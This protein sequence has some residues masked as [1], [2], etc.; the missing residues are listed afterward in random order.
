MKT[1]KTT[2]LLGL[3]IFGLGLLGSC[4]DIKS[5]ENQRGNTL[6]HSIQSFDHKKRTA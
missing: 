2:L 5:D 1:L 3:G 6:N 4:Q